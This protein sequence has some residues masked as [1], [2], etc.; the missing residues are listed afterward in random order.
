MIEIYW[1]FRKVSFEMK[2]HAAYIIG[3]NVEI[4]LEESYILL[5]TS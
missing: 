4:T 3:I 2:I 5:F 1:H